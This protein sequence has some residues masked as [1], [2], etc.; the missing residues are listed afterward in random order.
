VALPKGTAMAQ[1]PA[2]SGVAGRCFAIWLGSGGVIHLMLVSDRIREDVVPVDGLISRARRMSG[3]GQE[4]LA[5]RA[6]TSRPTLS[7]YE[8]GRKSPSLVTVQ[9]I[10]EAAGFDLDL[11]PTPNFH[12]VLTSRGRVVTVPDR[13]WRLPIEWAFAEVDL[14]LHLEWSM[15]GR[16]V[17]LRERAR[18]E[19]VYEVV[20]REGLADDFLTYI[21]GA[22]LMDSWSEL[23]IPQD[24]RLLWEPLISSRLAGSA[25]IGLGEAS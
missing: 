17:S 8:H 7:A 4:E 1:M 20:I 19:R 23:V 3:L 21:D 16:R 10:V 15:P 6:G 18:R 11:I 2:L 5:R 25:P 9:R 12:E 14:P 13:L 22:L 24:V